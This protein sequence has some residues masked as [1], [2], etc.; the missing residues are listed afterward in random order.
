MRKTEERSETGRHRDNIAVASGREVF[1]IGP[2][3]V[4]QALGP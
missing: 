2:H 3:Y 1:Q 4:H